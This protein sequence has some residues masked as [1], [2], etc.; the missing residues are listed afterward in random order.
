MGAKDR[1]LLEACFVLHRRPYRETSLLVDVFARDKGLLRLLAKGATRGKG[2]RAGLLQPFAPLS[3]SWAGNL[4]LP[5]LTE[6]ESAG[7]GYALAGAALFCGLY[8]NELLL[9]LLPTQ[10]SHPALFTRYQGLLV[11]LASGEA[12]EPHLRFFELSLLDELGYGLLLDFEAAGA[13][14]IR[15]DRHY[16]YHIEEGARPSEPRRGAVHG[17]TLLGLRRRCLPGPLEISEAKQLM[18]FVLG[19]YLGG[20]P[21]KSR[22]LFKGPGRR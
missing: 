11:A 14:P 5:T 3:L 18:R 17:S 7:P 6:A 9:R 15:A 19:H 20:K 22:E 21:L 16:V 8:L 4:E 2:G 13:E 10:D 12:A 1:V